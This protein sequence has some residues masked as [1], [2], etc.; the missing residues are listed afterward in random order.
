MS[1]HQTKKE[2][3]LKEK[4]NMIHRNNRLYIEFI[5]KK[6]RNEI[7]KQTSFYYKKNKKKI[8]IK[9][10][11]YI[12]ER[13][14]IDPKFRMINSL[15]RQ[16]NR[17][18]KGKIRSAHTAE[19]VGCSWDFLMD[20]FKSKFYN[21]KNNDEEMTMG[22]YGIRGWVIDH[23]KPLSSFDLSDPDQQKIACHWTNLQPL[24]WED[25]LEKS[26]RLDW[27]PWFI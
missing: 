8:L 16:I 1:I 10:A 22:K 6:H 27:E 20:H 21:R 23:I 11:I 12:R 5:T 9:M 24:W 25:N 18:F 19:L 4:K 2:S 7:L 3:A 14:R 13:R 26:D 17:Y 15:R